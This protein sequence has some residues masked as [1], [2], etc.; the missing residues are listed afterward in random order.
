MN[1]SLNKKRV[2]WMNASLKK[3]KTTCFLKVPQN[4]TNYFVATQ[5]G[6]L[7][8]KKNKQWLTKKMETFLDQENENFLGTKKMETFLDQE[9]E[10]FLR[11]RKWKQF[12]KKRKKPL[13]SKLNY[14]HQITLCSSFVFGKAKP[15][16]PKTATTERFFLSL[17]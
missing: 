5:M 6:L 14:K 7:C 17:F 1:P 15:N 9:N 2:S 11:P 13:S 16:F 3:K 10:N 8:V 12:L 4:R